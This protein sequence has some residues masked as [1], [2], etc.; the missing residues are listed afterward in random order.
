MWDALGLKGDCYFR[1]CN[2][3]NQSKHRANVTELRDKWCGQKVKYLCVS[4]TYAIVHHL[5][6]RIV[7]G[8][9]R[10]SVGG[11]SEHFDP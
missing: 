2:C 11:K 6:L 3:Q 4:A 5:H 10:T 8:R 7:L 9:I 1:P